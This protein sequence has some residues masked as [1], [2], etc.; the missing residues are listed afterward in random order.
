MRI[1][2]RVPIMSRHQAGRGFTLVELLV[3]ISI[4]GVLMSLLLPAVNSAREA[5]R[6]TQCLNNI[7]QLMTATISFEAQNRRYPSGGWGPLWVGDPDRGNGPGSPTVL[8][9]AGQPGGW[10][11]SILPFIEQT[12]QHDLGVGDPTPALKK[13]HSALR[14]VVQLPGMSC[15]SRRA[16]SP[17]PLLH[18][19]NPPPPWLPTG[20][21]L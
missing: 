17:I 3:V 21:P 10:L 20:T 7:K 8:T 2:A 4:I 12:A 1:R 16:G 13:Q 15:P 9:D 19:P 6:R 5:G 11:Y 18:N 14:C